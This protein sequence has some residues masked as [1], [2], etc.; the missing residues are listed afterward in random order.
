MAEE[1][2]TPSPDLEMACEHVRHLTGDEDTSVEFQ[3]INSTN[4]VNCFYGT[5]RELWGDIETLN[6]CQYNISILPNAGRDDGK[7]SKASDINAIRVMCLG[8]DALP[9]QWHLPPSFI[10]HTSPGRG[11]GYWR[12][13]HD[14]WR[15]SGIKPEEFN[16]IQKRAHSY[17]GAGSDAGRLGIHH[18]MRLAGT[19]RWKPDQSTTLAKLEIGTDRTYTR[20]QFLQ[21]LPELPPESERKKSNLSGKPVSAA[22]LSESWH[23]S[24]SSASSRNSQSDVQ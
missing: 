23:R 22:Q 13:G 9:S 16:A 20:E 21:G 7:A 15:V 3:C 17:Y 1:I 12:V 5:V 10:V 2:E 14:Y 18:L 8:L 4:D 6:L 11:H 19:L 24:L